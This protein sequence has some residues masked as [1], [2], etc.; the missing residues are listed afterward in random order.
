MSDK[1]ILKC[2]ALS[3]VVTSTNPRLSAGEIFI[4]SGLA[5]I[6]VFSICSAWS[7]VVIGF[8]LFCFCLLIF[9]CGV[10]V[11]STLWGV[12]LP[13]I[14]GLISVDVL[15][16]FCPIKG[17]LFGL[18]FEEKYPAYPSLVPLFA[19]VEHIVPVQ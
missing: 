2:T 16:D 9:I 10:E 15:V 3:G 18:N 19:S 11:D 14:S 12:L 17:A 1:F 7:N 8:G 5:G 4:S 13:I 6:C